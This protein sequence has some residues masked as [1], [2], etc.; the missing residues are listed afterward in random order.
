MPKC[1]S[2][3]FNHNTGQITVKAVLTE[4]NDV[5]NIGLQNFIYKKIF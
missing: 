1:L 5:N 3:L 2:S 4:F